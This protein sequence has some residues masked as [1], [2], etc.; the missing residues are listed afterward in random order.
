MLSL[1]QTAIENNLEPYKYLTSLL[2]K[3]KDADL[4][5]DRVIQILLPWNVP[6]ESYTYEKTEEK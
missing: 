2:G 4:A 6:A 5:D 1:I 3:A